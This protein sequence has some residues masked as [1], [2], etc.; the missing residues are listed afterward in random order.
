MSLV[1]RSIVLVIALL[2]LTSV[3]CGGEP[4]E[5]ERQQAQEAIL[6]ARAAGAEQYAHEEF[7]AATTAL[8]HANE[9]INQRD[10][11]LALNHALDSRE[12]AQTAAKMAADGKAAARLEADHA[13]ASAADLLA[14]MRTRIAEADRSRT[15]ARLLMNP[16]KVMAAAERQVQE[17]RTAY[18]K[19]DYARATTTAQDAV[20]P[21]T[22]AL[23]DLPGAPAPP[24][25][26]R[27]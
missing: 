18:A 17:A 7:S 22:A 27:R 16:Q 25:R 6:A 21:I 3:S 11:R 24:T 15:P 9:A 8:E 23:Q 10:Y 20:V 19:A 5:K 13:I 1:R 14:S 26:R 2:V 4:P 12:R